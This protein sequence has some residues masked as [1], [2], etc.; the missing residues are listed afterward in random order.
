MHSRWEHDRH[1]HSSDRITV[2]HA[3]P[4]HK[5]SKQ[6]TRWTHR[7]DQLPATYQATVSLVSDPAKA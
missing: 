7:R 5:R 4:D 2:E 6:P 1:W 3:L